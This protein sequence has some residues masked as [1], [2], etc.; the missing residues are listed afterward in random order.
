MAILA[1]VAITLGLFLL[2]LVPALLE[3]VQ[4]RDT[5]PLPIAVDFD[6]HP[7]RF[8]TSFR[9]TVAR[10]LGGDPRLV[11]PSLV[12]DDQYLHGS[13]F[14]IVDRSGRPRFDV[15]ELATQSTRKMLLSG[16]TLYLPNGFTF[17]QEVF[18]I[19]D[20]CSGACS[21]LRAVFCARELR[22]AAGSK[23]MR[24]A[25]AMYIDIG[26]HCEIH[27]RASAEKVIIIHPGAT[28]KRLNAPRIAFG[29]IQGAGDVF[30]TDSLKL[31]AA[32]AGEA[33]LNKIPLP[34]GDNRIIVDGDLHI[35][36]GGHVVGDVIAYGNL[37]LGHSARIVGS[38]KTHKNLLMA[39]RASIEGAA[40][41]VNDVVVGADAFIRGPVIAERAIRLCRGSRIGTLD[42]QTSA[43]APVISAEPG[44]SAFG[45]LWAREH[46]TALNHSASAT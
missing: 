38:I 4:K 14:H 25:H 13:G 18:G 15:K 11:V 19:A 7:E 24:W 9:A 36:A 17:E 26:E 33:L 20:I 2:S 10:H 45:T 39:A 3:I 37:H 30:V 16:V 8:A 31:P 35:P 1:L 32:A 23:V 5:A 40:V 22:L 28:F 44:A 42:A 46:G 21:I 12:R 34:E 29:D 6:T 41:A 43:V 27:G